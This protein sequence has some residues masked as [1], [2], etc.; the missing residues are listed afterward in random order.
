MKLILATTAL[1]LLP[2]ASALAQTPPPKN[3]TPAPRVSPFIPV[4]NLVPNI[5][6][7]HWQVALV[8]GD[9]NRRSQFCGGTLIAAGWVL[10]AAQCVD[11]PKV[12]K[13]PKRLDV[14]AETLNYTTG[15]VRS[16]VD[17]IFIHPKW[18][19]TGTQYDF[20][21]AL[22]K[23]KTPV[24]S[25]QPI[26]VISPTGTLPDGTEVRVTGWG[27]LSE[28]GPGSAVLM[29]VNVPVISN[30]VCNDPASYGGRVSAQM[31]C[32]GLRDG[33]LDSCQGD[34]GGPVMSTISGSKEVVGIVSWGFGCARRL[35]YGVYTR[36]TTVSQWVSETMAGN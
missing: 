18:G 4:S 32:A 24:T 30:A 22:L 2:T 29:Q 19:Q 3:G 21:A 35:K 23:L 26:N 31:F 28:G 34:S 10:T 15:G 33:G 13:D 17:K 16:D 9:D 27:A 14:I 7:A 12:Q 36:V 1:F 6:D 8:D 11:N 20:D 5:S 25:V